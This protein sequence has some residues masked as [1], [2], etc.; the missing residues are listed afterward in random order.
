MI[1]TSYSPYPEAYLDIIKG[2]NFHSLNFHCDA[3]AKVQ[4]LRYAD[5][6]VVFNMEIL[7]LV[8]GFFR[9]GWDPCLDKVRCIRMLRSKFVACDKSDTVPGPTNLHLKVHL[10]RTRRG[11]YLHG[12]TLITTPSVVS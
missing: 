10:S 5:R 3:R 12:Q 8:V 1:C 2:I 11:E 6:R 7:E 4:V 9:G